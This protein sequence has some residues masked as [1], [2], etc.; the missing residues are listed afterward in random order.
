LAAPVETLNR[1]F[2]FIE[3]DRDDALCRKAF[4][5]CSIE[6]LNESHLALRVPDSMKNWLSRVARNGT[7]DGWRDELGWLQVAAIESIVSAEMPRYGYKLT[8]T[9]AQ[10]RLWSLSRRI[11]KGVKDGVGRLAPYSV[12]RPLNGIRRAF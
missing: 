9:P 12:K 2:E 6:R 3:L 7:A 8:S 1:V 4:E 11:G 5:A 10:R